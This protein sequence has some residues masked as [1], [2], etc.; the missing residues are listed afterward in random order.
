MSLAVDP[1]VDVTPISWQNAWLQ[2][3][4]SA[5]RIRNGTVTSQAQRIKAT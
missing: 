3:R 2:C 1:D 4:S 5:V